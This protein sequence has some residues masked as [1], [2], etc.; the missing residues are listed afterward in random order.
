MFIYLV[1]QNDNE[2]SF[3]K[4]NARDFEYFENEKEAQEAG[5]KYH[6]E[7]GKWMWLPLSNNHAAGVLGEDGD[8]LAGMVQ[9]KLS[10]RKFK[11]DNKKWKEIDAW[12]LRPQTRL[13][14]FKVRCYIY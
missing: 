8:H 7:N 6:N 11:E 3:W 1:D 4:G 10:L 14:A 2:V 9:V 5:G 12:R 13:K